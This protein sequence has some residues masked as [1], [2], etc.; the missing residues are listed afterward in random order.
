MKERSV[1][2]SGGIYGRVYMERIVQTEQDRSSGPALP[3]IGVCDLGKGAVPFCGPVS[4]PAIMFT[5]P[6]A[7]CFLNMERRYSSHFPEDMLRLNEDGVVLKDFKGFHIT[8][9]CV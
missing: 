9:S 5:R 4:M 1:L 3:R 7:Q 8:P 6:F 2:G